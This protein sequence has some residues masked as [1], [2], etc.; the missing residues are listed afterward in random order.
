LREQGA[1]RTGTIGL[2]NRT[3]GPLTVR[4]TPG[5]QLDADPS[6]VV[7]A[8]GVAAI[9]VRAKD[10]EHG[11]IRDSVTITGDDLKVSIPV[12]AAAEPD[13]EPAGEP[14]PEPS[15]PPA[16]PLP[17][18]GRLA[19]AAS[20]PAAPALPDAPADSA[21]VPISTPL[22]EPA[23]PGG[24]EPRIAIMPLAVG[25]AGQNAASVSCDI[26]GA[27]PVRAWRLEQQTV[28]IDTAGQPVA[29]WQPMANAT[30]QVSG[31]TVSAALAG[32]MPGALYVVRL[33]GVDDQQRIVAITAAA[34]VWTLRA[35]GGT[36][37]LW[38]ALATAALAF[39]AWKWRAGRT[40]RRW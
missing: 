13:L 20:A 3:D 5:P 24:A 11:A 14:S 36:H 30:V 38:L 18:P 34:P 31:T 16:A 12:Y 1:I 8:K 15:A 19:A 21:L 23:D 29:K 22:A 26:K 40:R 9:S 33:V 17:G 27:A 7:P 10:R 2:A 37:W 4:L 6:A 28:G 25:G 35:T 32:L 39:A